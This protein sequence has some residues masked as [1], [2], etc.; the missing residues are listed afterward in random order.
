M[1]D[2]YLKKVKKLK[3]QSSPEDLDYI[4]LCKAEVPKEKKKS[5][6]D[7]KA[8]HDFDSPDD[9]TMT[10][11]A[12]NSLD[13]PDDELSVAIKKKKKDKKEK[14]AK[15]ELESE[16]TPVWDEAEMKVKKEKKVKRESGCDITHAC[17]EAELRDR[18][19]KKDKKHKQE[20]DTVNVEH[21]TVVQEAVEPIKVKKE[22][23]EKAQEYQ[24]SDY[25]A[26]PSRRSSNESV[27]IS[28]PS[29]TAETGGAKYW[30]RID[31]EKW[32]SKVEGTK[33]ARISHYDKGGDS[34]GNE[35]AQILGQV[36]GKGFVK[37]MQKLKRASWKGQGIIDTGVNSVQFSDWED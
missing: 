30:K 36:K 22:K 19:D 17:E 12:I 15:R 37:A 28:T 11:E 25:L 26:T 31:E 29:G 9:V 4:D 24:D 32:K 16:A 14:K 5:K 34:W 13:E 10:V 33:F 7:K 27:P 1:P 18:K 8:V 35:A 3:R 23:K 20:S 6:K 2:E 21:A